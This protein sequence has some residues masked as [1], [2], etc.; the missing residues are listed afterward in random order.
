MATPSLLLLRHPSALLAVYLAATCALQLNASAG[1]LVRW[2]DYSVLA[3]VMA[4][5]LL[6]LRHTLIVG[7][8]T[9]A[10]SVVIYGF[11]IPGVSEGGRTVVIAAAF[12]S[13][14]MSLVICRIR[15]RRIARC[16]FAVP[17]PSGE[18][19]GH[20]ASAPRQAPRDL[21]ASLLAG[22]PPAGRLPQPAAVELAYG[23]AE[24][25]TPQAHWLDAIPLPGARV[26]LVA[27]SVTED[28]EPA[29]TLVPEL[30]AAIRTLAD[31]D[32]QPDET[33]SHLQDVLHRLQPDDAAHDV[34]ARCLY[35][36]YDPVTADCTLACAGH[37][38]P[39]VINPEGVTIAVDLPAGTPLGRTRP[40]VATAEIR[41]SKGSVLLLH[42]HSAKPTASETATFGST[43][44]ARRIEPQ[45]SLAATCRTALQALA[46]EGGPRQLRVLA[47]RT[48]TLD[49]TTVATWDL[50]ADP[51][52]VSAAR[53]H[54]TAQL[55]A[56][57]LAEAAPTTILIVSELVTNAI[58]H[59]Q[60][61]LHLRLIRCDTSLTCEVTDGSTT[62]PHLRRARTL[63]EGGRG[64][65][66]VAQLTCRW[67]TR[68]HPQ[69]KTIWAEHTPQHEA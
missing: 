62:T 67:G 32:M 5:A 40:H 15:V 52:A 7:A 47:A 9:L 41:L 55:T 24:N 64:L 30:R 16:A 65:F 54:V 36:V 44:P 28:G 20:M 68:H 69:G 2:S 22:G 8:A 10:T 1:G 25:G 18:R 4:A 60:P 53:K 66:I 12:L 49:T 13:L 48:R 6:P 51:A 26:A 43:A 45:S 37:P 56:W 14:G 29:P 42:A 33:L 39:I 19:T 46:T 61:P 38:A 57:D 17:A 59:A 35:A 23:R 58:R 21:C 3:P 34:T 27:G 63:D 11:A 31:I 50:T